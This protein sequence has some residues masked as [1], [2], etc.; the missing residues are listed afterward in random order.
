MRSP[1]YAVQHGSCV[2]RSQTVFT[3]DLRSRMAFVHCL[4]EFVIP[5]P[6]SAVPFT[7][8]AALVFV[9]MMDHVPS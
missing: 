5:S 2:F 8:P 6:D 3:G 4:T 7:E 1:E 9:E